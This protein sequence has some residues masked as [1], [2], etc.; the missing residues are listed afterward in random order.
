MD[1]ASDVHLSI[2]E[3]LAAKSKFLLV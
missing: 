3:Y 2:F 1:L